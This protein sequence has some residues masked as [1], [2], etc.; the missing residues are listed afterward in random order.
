MPCAWTWWCRKVP[1]MPSVLRS[2]RACCWMTAGGSGL[3]PGMTVKVAFEVG[4]ATRL[5]VPVSALIRRGELSAVYVVGADHSVGLR[6]LRL[7]HRFGDK[8]E[9]LAGLAPG[10]RVARDPEAAA[11]YLVKR[12]DGVA[13]P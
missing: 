9:V 4:A 10:D 2:V 8:V 7:G 5:L 13:Q 1:S 12:H 6:Q 11:L 3:H